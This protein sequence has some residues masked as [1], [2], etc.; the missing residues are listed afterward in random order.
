MP[1]MNNL[2]KRLQQLELVVGDPAQYWSNLEQE[3]RETIEF[4]RAAREYMGEPPKEIKLSDGAPLHSILYC[5][6]LQCVRKYTRAGEP[7]SKTDH[8]RPPEFPP[9][10]RKAAK[11]MRHHTSRLS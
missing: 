3:R 10:I 6:F 5:W 4:I 8:P 1:T 11:M 9:F 7:E 2:E